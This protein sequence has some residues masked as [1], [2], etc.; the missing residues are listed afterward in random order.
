MYSATSN[1]YYLDQSHHRRAPQL[2]VVERLL[3]G[4]NL[5]I[6][7]FG[8]WAQIGRTKVYQEIS[9]GRLRIAKVGSRTVVPAP[10]ALRWIGSQK[11]AA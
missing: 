4:G 6:P 7:E 8:A 1:I 10:E 11:M 3:S 2:S 5:S 9:E